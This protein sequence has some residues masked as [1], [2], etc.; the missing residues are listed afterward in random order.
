MKAYFAKAI[1]DMYAE[2]SRAD[3]SQAICEYNHRPSN[4]LGSMPCVLY[5]RTY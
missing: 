5:Y 4:F 1:T 2:I 3:S